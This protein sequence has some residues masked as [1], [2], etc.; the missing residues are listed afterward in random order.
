MDILLHEFISVFDEWMRRLRECVGRRGEY[1]WIDQPT[2]LEF[3]PLENT[4]RTTRLSTPPVCHYA[5][6]SSAIFI[7]Y[8]YV[9]DLSGRP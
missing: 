6:R 5:R 2:S 1:F 3:L 9:T 8:P 7:E 4:D